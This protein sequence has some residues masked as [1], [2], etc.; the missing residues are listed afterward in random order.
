MSILLSAVLAMSVGAAQAKSGQ[1]IL[2]EHVSALQQAKSLSV[3]FTVQKL[4][5]AAQEYQLDFSKP[6]MLRLTTPEGVIVTDGKTVWE[7]DKKSNE[8]L[9]SPGGVNAVNKLMQEPFFAWTAFFYPE[10]FKG[11]RTIT[12][13][14]RQTVKG[15]QVQPIS[16]NPGGDPTILATLLID[17][18][19]KIARGATF[20][21]TKGAQTSE[22]LVLASEVNIS[23]VSLENGIFAFSPPA[24]AKKVEFSSKDLEKWYHDLDEAIS[25]A[26][27]TDRMIFL[28]VYAEWCGPC[29]ALKANVFPTPEFR[30]M[31]KYF[32]FVA[33]DGDHNRG[34]MEKFGVS[35]YPTLIFL[36]KDGTEV[37]RRVGGGNTSMIIDEMN[38]A[39]QMAGK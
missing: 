16:F 25:V 38:K 2:N 7:Y 26:K 21:V 5:A 14:N 18:S 36:R 4:P 15:V 12:V 20:K 32:V 35:A 33:I 9:E 17:E 3:K 1:T 23:D 37:H 39:R 28:D 22:T 10:Q 34:I 19:N 30:A 27:A 6:G 13:G 24:G 8:Y 29:Q 31:S 11:V